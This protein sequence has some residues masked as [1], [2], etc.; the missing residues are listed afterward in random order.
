MF[1]GEVGGSFSPPPLEGI[2]Q[3]ALIYDGSC[4]KPCFSSAWG[5][6]TAT[7]HAARAVSFLQGSSPEGR[8]LRQGDPLPMRRRMG[9]HCLLHPPTSPPLPLALMGFPLDPSSLLVHPRKSSSPGLFHHP[10]PQAHGRST[11]GPA[12]PQHPQ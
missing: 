5:R 11:P 10:R 3:P 8:G 1:L 12:H 9:H 6:F 4:R 2:A 7:F